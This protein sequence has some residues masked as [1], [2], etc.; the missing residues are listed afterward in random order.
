MTELGFGSQASAISYTVIHSTP[1]D[2]STTGTALCVEACGP[3]NTP[4]S[5]R[6]NESKN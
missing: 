2:L 1:T 5:G 3:R 4:P 6:E